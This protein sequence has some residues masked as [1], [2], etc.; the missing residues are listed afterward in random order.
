MRF[1]KNLAKC[2]MHVR[3]LHVANIKSKAVFLIIDNCYPVVQSDNVANIFRALRGSYGPRWACA[4]FTAQGSNNLSIFGSQP[5]TFCT[6][7]SQVL[8][9]ASI[10]FIAFHTIL[11]SVWK[12]R[13]QTSF[14]RPRNYHVG[15][16]GLNEA[17]DRHAPNQQII[18]RNFEQRIC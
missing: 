6:L 17:N 2:N 4:V 10:F 14:I 5:P 11:S 16:I 13:F 3:R 18:Y 1:N 7:G 15:K 8:S 12:L 9:Y